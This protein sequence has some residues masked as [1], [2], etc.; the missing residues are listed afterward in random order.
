M[1]TFSLREP[2]FPECEYPKSGVKIQKNDKNQI[3]VVYHVAG[4]ARTAG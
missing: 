3:L 1:Y 2:K 4:Y